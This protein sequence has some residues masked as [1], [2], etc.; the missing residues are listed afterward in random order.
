[1]KKTLFALTGLL[2]C[3]SMSGTG[4]ADE[5]PAF[6]FDRKIRILL[7]VNAPAQFRV[8]DSEFPQTPP[9]PGIVSA[10][11]DRVAALVVEQDGFF[12]A[13]GE[14]AGHRNTPFWIWV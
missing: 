6:D 9:Q 8:S 1:M 10:D 2:L 14:T 12:F 7:L 3:L 13:F 5:Y 11:C 4:P